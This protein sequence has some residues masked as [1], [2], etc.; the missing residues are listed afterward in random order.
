MDYDTFGNVILDTHPGFQPFGFAGG[1]YD[2]LTG[3]VRF[4]ARDYNP[5]TGRWT[6]K[7]PVG[8]TGNFNLYTYANSDPV[9]LT[10]PTGKY[11]QCFYRNVGNLF[12]L[13]GIGSAGVGTVVGLGTIAG[14]GLGVLGVGLTGF[15]LGIAINCAH[16]L[17][18][19]TATYCSD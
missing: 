3:L 17:N 4:G 7:D 10:D 16:G 11:A 5:Q 15:A 9:N 13:F 6:A 19:F 2:S 18:T 14:A 8:F 12:L 1:L